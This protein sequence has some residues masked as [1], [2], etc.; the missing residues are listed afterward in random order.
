M[1]QVLVSR[2]AVERNDQAETDDPVFTVVDCHGAEHLGDSVHFNGPSQLRYDRNKP[3]GRRIWIE[4]FSEVV[5]KNG[6]VSTSIFPHVVEFRGTG[7]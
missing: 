2:A 1:T 6:L 4:T 7:K 5:V 3:A